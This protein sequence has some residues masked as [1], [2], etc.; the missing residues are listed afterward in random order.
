MAATSEQQ[1]ADKYFV[2]SKN[3]AAT[4]VMLITSSTDF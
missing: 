2:L 1:A 4:Q 3:G